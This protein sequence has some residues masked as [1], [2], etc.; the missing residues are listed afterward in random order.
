MFRHSLALDLILRYSRYSSFGVSVK[1]AVLN[2]SETSTP[3]STN[4]P[5]SLSQQSS[6]NGPSWPRI[7]P[8]VIELTQIPTGMR[9]QCESTWCFF[10]ERLNWVFMTPSE[11]ET[12]LFF[13]FTF[14]LYTQTGFLSPIC[15]QD[16]EQGLKQKT[17]WKQT[18]VDRFLEGSHIWKDTLSMFRRDHYPWASTA[19]L[20]RFCQVGLCQ[21]M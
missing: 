8:K 21:V 7:N 2:T 12:F 4:F 14:T 9:P 17:K 15:I 20:L 13:V 19:G 10:V 1:P 6:T 3:P 11:I 16:E 5:R 18:K